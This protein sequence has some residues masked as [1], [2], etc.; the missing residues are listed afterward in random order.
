MGTPTPI[1][2]LEKV[3]TCLGFESVL[4]VLVGS[5]LFFLKCFNYGLFSREYHKS[6]SAEESEDTTWRTLR[7]LFII[8]IFVWAVYISFIVFF[9]QIFTLD[10]SLFT[11]NPLI[12]DETVPII[13]SLQIVFYITT[14]FQTLYFFTHIYKLVSSLKS[15]DPNFKKKVDDSI[16][17]NED[18][19]DEIKF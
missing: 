19:E 12:F 18:T 11:A 5:S 10:T 16:V 17:V 2:Q 7:K 14:T 3:Y 8:F 6:L 4:L 1:L 15:V 9:V 13:H